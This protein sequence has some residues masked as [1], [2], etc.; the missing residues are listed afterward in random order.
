M[1]DIRSLLI[2]IVIG[3]AITI[4]WWILELKNK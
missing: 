2:G 4:F 3:T 1:I